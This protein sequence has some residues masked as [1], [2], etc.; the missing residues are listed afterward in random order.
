MLRY[1]KSLRSIVLKSTGGNQRRNAWTNKEGKIKNYLSY[2]WEINAMSVGMLAKRVTL[3]NFRCQVCFWQSTIWPLTIVIGTVLL[4]RSPGW[5]VIDELECN[6]AFKLHT[7]LWKK[8]ATDYVFV[9][10]VLVCCDIRR[11]YFCFSALLLLLLFITHQS[12]AGF[13]REVCLENCYMGRCEA[14]AYLT[15]NN[16]ICK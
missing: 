2:S 4:F 15:T 8:F 5:I 10:M 6:R 7:Q 12:S 9:A 13:S 11:T 16:Y 3:K 14:V 1:F